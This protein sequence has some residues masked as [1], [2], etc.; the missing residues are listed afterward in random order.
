MTEEQANK[1]IDLLEVIC[2]K[3][4]D[5]H[6]AVGYIDTDDVVNAV[7]NLQGEVRRSR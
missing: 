6:S 1:M 5:I 4:D 2:S 7:K 3:L